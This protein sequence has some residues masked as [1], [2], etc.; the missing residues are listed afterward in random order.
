LFSV[1]KV[2]EDNMREER[3]LKSKHEQHKYEREECSYIE[4]MA[5]LNHYCR[6]FLLE[7]AH[8]QIR[9]KQLLKKKNIKGLLRLEM[10]SEIKNFEHSFSMYKN[11]NLIEKISRSFDNEYFTS[12]LKFCTEGENILMYDLVDKFVNTL[13][14]QVDANI[15]DNMNAVKAD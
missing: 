14:K 8:V 12:I 10:P 1:V 7:M 4:C 9:Q 15:E 2:L 11:H 3:N 5:L 13:F 6:L